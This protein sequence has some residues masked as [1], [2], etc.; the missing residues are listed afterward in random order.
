MIAVMAGGA[1]ASDTTIS[2]RR[3]KGRTLAEFLKE[4]PLSEAEQKLLEA[5]ATGATASIADKRPDQGTEA[6]CIRGDFVRF[7]ALGGDDGAPVHEHG[8]RL[9][10]AWIDGDV[11]LE[12]CKLETELTLSSC[13]ITGEL[14]LRDA[15]IFGLNLAD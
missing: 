9:N 6:N 8:V 2:T 13:T 1:M 11:D 7:L 14:V 3:P 4:G 5:C 12:N 10:G 15:S